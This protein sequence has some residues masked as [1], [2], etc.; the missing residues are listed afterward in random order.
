MGLMALSPGEVLLPVY[1]SAAGTGMAGFALLSV[2]FLA[3]TVLGMG[4]LTCLASL[5]ASVIR[6]EQWAR[7]ESAILGLALIGLGLVLL[8]RP[9]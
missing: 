5:G 1:L 7:H 3:G 6:L 2:A 9:H 4:L 8:L